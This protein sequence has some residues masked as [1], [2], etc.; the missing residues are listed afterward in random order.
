MAETGGASLKPPSASLPSEGT[1]PELPNTLKHVQELLTTKLFQMPFSKLLGVLKRA[2][3]NTDT[4][5]VKSS[6]ENLIA[7]GESQGVDLANS[8]IDDL[9]AAVQT[10]ENLDSYLA[11]LNDL[12]DLK[13]IGDA[14]GI[15]LHSLTVQDFQ[16]IVKTPQKLNSIILERVNKAKTSTESDVRVLDDDA[17]MALTEREKHVLL[18]QQKTAGTPAEKN[19]EGHF[20]L[21]HMLHREGFYESAI[22]HYNNALALNPSHPS[23]KHMLQALREP[24]LDRAGRNYVTDLFDYYA[25]NYDTHMIGTL[26]YKA[27]HLIFETLQ[28]VTEAGVG[29]SLELHGPAKE[30]KSLLDLGCGTGLAGS[31]FSSHMDVIVGVDLSSNMIK[32]AASRKVYSKLI[33]ADVLKF[34]TLVP[35]SDFDV[36]I[37]SDVLCYIGDLR[38]LFQSVMSLLKPDGLVAFTIEAMDT[39]CRPEKYLIDKLSGRFKHCAEYLQEYL[40]S[41]GFVVL[42]NETVQLRLQNREGVSGQL[43]VL[44][45]NKKM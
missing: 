40:R 10:E 33:V 9:Q 34:V 8:A 35:E 2:E 7:L 18:L 45:R 20:Q 43:M 17:T 36:V 31:L 27:H 37:L 15:D 6:I 11:D 25:P 44:T 4:A 41:I 19:A 22:E 23:A 32:R 39:N 24:S 12:K 28:K 42:S 26:D 5:E 21:G 3:G 29:G 13:E 30:K 1:P 14:V 38:Q 16:G